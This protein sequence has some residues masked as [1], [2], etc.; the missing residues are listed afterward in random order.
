[1]RKLIPYLIGLVIV[2]AIVY[3]LWPKPIPVD[4]QSVARGPLEVTVDEEGKTR[5]KERYVVSAPLTGRLRRITM[6]AGDPVEA[7]KTL[8]AVIEP[9]DPAL[10]DARAG[11][12]AM[13][14]VNAAEAALSQARPNLERAQ[15]ALE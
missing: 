4:M 13:A 8:L 5:I 1:M 14:R 15:V 11:A 10:L 7:G 9:S 6:H 12:E 2:A 3:A